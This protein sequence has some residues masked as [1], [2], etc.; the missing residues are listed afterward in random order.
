MKAK[1]IR[2]APR[3]TALSLQLD[4]LVG[5]E[6]V[7]ILSGLIH[8]WHLK[9]PFEN[10]IKKLAQKANLTPTTV[11]RIMN[12]DTKSPRMLTCIMLF[13]ALGFSAVRFE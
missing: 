13:K 2:F 11:S 9:E 1:I 12:R 6:G 3:R 8:E 10:T 4:Q 5:F 7:K